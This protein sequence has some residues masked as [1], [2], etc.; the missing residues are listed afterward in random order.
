MTIYIEKDGE[1]YGINGNFE[2]FKNY[3]K[4]DHNFLPLTPTDK[5]DFEIGSRVYFENI[6]W[7]EVVEKENCS[8]CACEGMEESCGIARCISPDRADNRCVVFKKLITANKSTIDFGIKY[9]S[10]KPRPGLIPPEC[11]RAISEVLSYDAKKYAPDNWKKIEPEKYTDAMLRHYI[12]GR[13][14]GDRDKESG[15]LHAAHLATNAIFLLYFELH[16][17]GEEGK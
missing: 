5:R 16:K 7:T 1:F 2:E 9:D 14:D 6:G 10:D 3:P 8:E 13:I 15:L 12:D 4:G 17:A 11:I